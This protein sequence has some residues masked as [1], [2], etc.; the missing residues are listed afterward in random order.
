VDS[1]DAERGNSAPRHDRTLAIRP[2][3]SHLYTDVS[4]SA[5]YVNVFGIT[6]MRKTASDSSQL[7]E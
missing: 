5:F 4:Q 6:I 3:A 2:V 7:T 1:A